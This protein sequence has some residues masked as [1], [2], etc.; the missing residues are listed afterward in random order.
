MAVAT[1]LFIEVALL[2]ESLTGSTVGGL[3]FI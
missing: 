1:D 2:Y 3:K